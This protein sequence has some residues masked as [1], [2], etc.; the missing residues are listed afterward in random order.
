MAVQSVIFHRSHWSPHKAREW[1]KYHNLEPIKKVHTTENYYRYRI[2]LP[3]MF[4]KFR[5]K[6]LPNKVSLVLGF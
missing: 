3:T 1:L 2:D 5:I 6:H 4:S